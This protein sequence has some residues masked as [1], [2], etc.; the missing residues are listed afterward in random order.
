M[1]AHAIKGNQ[2]EIIGT[3]IGR[4]F[5]DSK[6]YYAVLTDSA[7]A[8]FADSNYATVET[9]FKDEQYFK[10]VVQ[11]HHPTKEQLGWYHSHPMNYEGYSSVD[12]ANQRKWGAPYHIGLLVVC[13]YAQDTFTVMAY[14]GPESELLMP[15]Y[16]VHKNGDHFASIDTKKTS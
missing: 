11:D 15:S 16:S 8:P 10:W 7:P 3:L 6:G 12:R 14:R 9:T 2:Y 4:S 1:I 13:N 5:Q